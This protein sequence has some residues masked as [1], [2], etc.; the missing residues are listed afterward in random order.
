M[1]TEV[2]ISV[3]VRFY[4]YFRFGRNTF[5]SLTNICVASVRY[6][7]RSLQHLFVSLSVRYIVYYRMPKGCQNL[8]LLAFLVIVASAK[9]ISTAPRAMERGL[10]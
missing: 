6:C 10:K 9:G 4:S 8:R 7:V 5:R 2:E 3:A 1:I